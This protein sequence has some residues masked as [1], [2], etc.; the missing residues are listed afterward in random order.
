MTE[1]L[2]KLD[3]FVDRMKEWKNE[4]FRRREGMESLLEFHRAAASAVTVFVKADASAEDVARASYIGCFTFAPK[5]M[6]VGFELQANDMAGL[7]CVGTD[8]MNVYVVICRFAE[9]EDGKHRKLHWTTKRE[10]VEGG[11]V[12]RASEGVRDAIN[13]VT[14]YEKVAAEGESHPFAHLSEEVLTAKVD[15]MAA[16]YMHAAMPFI[17]RVTLVSEFGS[18]R[19]STLVAYLGAPDMLIVNDR[20]EDDLDAEIARLLSDS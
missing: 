11:G 9:T 1:L 12:A 17:A 20:P 8:H 15:A 5:Q 13:V 14:I 7:V 19:Q 3:S 10:C 16:R 18:E 6:F 2:E 4:S